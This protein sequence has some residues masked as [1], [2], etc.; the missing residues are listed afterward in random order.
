MLKT[1]KTLVLK[2]AKVTGVK[3]A[4]PADRIGLGRGV[5]NYPTDNLSQG[6]FSMPH[7]PEPEQVR[8]REELSAMQVQQH[9]QADSDAVPPESSPGC[10]P[11]SSASRSE[12]PSASSLSG[13]WHRLTRTPP[14]GF[15][16]EVTLIVGTRQA[17]FSRDLCRQ[18]RFGRDCQSLRRLHDKRDAIRK[19]GSATAAG[20]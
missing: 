9:L 15:T 14:T 6:Q 7:N 13:S 16:R 10:F 20:K 4:T 11:G 8:P 19:V 17:D 12:S 5:A 18:D 1:L 2:T 3:L